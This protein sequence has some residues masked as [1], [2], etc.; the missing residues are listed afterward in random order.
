MISETKE[1][2]WLN[3][4]IPL[5]GLIMVA[6][7]ICGWGANIHFDV[8]NQAIELAK[9]KNT[10][11]SVTRMA[12]QMDTVAKDSAEIREN[13]KSITSLN[14]DIWMLQRQVMELECKTGGSCTTNT[15]KKPK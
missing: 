6:G 5:W 12:W 2:H 13:L 3:R 14:M 8:K 15:P 4:E 7:T 10:H 11:D 9:Y 1:R